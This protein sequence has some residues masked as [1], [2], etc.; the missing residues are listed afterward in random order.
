MFLDYPLALLELWRPPL[1]PPKERT[2]PPS[3]S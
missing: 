2:A 3:L 1:F